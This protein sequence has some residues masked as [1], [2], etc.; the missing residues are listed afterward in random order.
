VKAGGKLLG[1]GKEEEPVA[2]AAPTAGGDPEHDITVQAG[3][4]AI[5]EGERSLVG[6]SRMSREDATKVAEKVKAEHPVFHTL[7]VVDGGSTWDFAYT[8]SPAKE[9]TGRPKKEQSPAIAAPNVWDEI[10]EGLQLAQEEQ[11]RLSET[12]VRFN[13]TGSS[14]RCVVSGLAVW[15]SGQSAMPPRSRT[16]DHGGHGLDGELHSHPQAEPR[17]PGSRPSPAAWRLRHYGVD[18][19]GAC[20]LADVRHPQA[21]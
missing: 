15:R 7:D 6:D 10:V 3:L 2:K 8:A 14:P 11:T 21:M 5:D 19:P 16:A 13:K 18:P 9:K 20:C 1:F 12:S 4:V 17:R